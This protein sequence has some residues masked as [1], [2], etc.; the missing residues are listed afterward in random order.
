MIRRKLSINTL[1]NI[2]GTAIPLAVGALTLPFLMR[3]LGTEKVGLLAILWTLIG[4]F[5]LFDLGLGRAITMLAANSIA[6]NKHEDTDKIIRI[7]TEFTLLIGFLAGMALFLAAPAI[8]SKILNVNPLLIQDTEDALKISAM[9]I[10][11]A[12]L[13]SAF[14]GALEAHES[15]LRS[16]IAKITL[17]IL[18]FFFPVVGIL[19]LN[20]KVTTLAICL[21]VARLISTVF[22]F[23]YTKQY[24]FKKNF[25]LKR[26]F[27]EI[28]RL[29]TISFWIAISNAISPLMVSADRF[30]I[31]YYLGASQ[32]AYYTIP[33]E[34]ITRLLI[35][36]SAI[37]TTLLPHL[38]K[39][40]AISAEN[41]DSIY[42]KSYK[43]NFLILAALT[44]IAAISAYP[45]LHF[46]FSSEFAEK[47]TLVSVLL[48]VGVLINGMAYMPYTALHSKNKV[49]FVAGMHI[50]E[51]FIYF[52]MLIFLL[53]KFSLA[54]AAIAWVIRVAIDFL[55]LNFLNRQNRKSG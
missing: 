24:Y 28:K 25:T 12:T 21:I 53:Q 13:T 34:F 14:R 50:L 32:V 8:A 55:G 41:A 45:V 27:S 52:P 23:V 18:L 36:P 22:Y 4:Y 2:A 7:G 47:S 20:D 44:S 5:S 49:K 11:L 40:Y 15:F 1:Y 46:F 6:Q 9:G 51:L 35:I 33:L 54:G 37:G 29:F 17:G 42:R 26:D 30:I 19:L 43:M 38:S 31:S 39:T 16:N 10:P 3:S 48:C